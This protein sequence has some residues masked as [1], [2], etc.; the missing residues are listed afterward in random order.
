MRNGLPIVVSDAFG[1][2]ANKG[3]AH[4]DLFDAEAVNEAL[5]VV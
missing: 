1:Y 2:F 3:F 5:T 4:A